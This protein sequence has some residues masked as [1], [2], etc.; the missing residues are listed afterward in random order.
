MEPVDLD[1][2]GT[3]IGFEEPAL[4][5]EPPPVP[6]DRGGR[7]E[8]GLLAGR[9]HLVAV[10]AGEGSDLELE[11]QDPDPEA[12]AQLAALLGRDGIAVDEEVLVGAELSLDIRADVIDGIVEDNL[13][14]ERLLG[15]APRDLVAELEFVLVPWPPARREARLEP[16]VAESQQIR[17]DV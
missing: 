5:Q 7:A 15:A 2:D 13:A 12:D 14:V 9:G 10:H 6:A 1:L 4:A 16:I 17:I 8:E 11:R 3:D